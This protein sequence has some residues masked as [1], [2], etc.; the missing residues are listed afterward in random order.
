MKVSDLAAKAFDVKVK[1]RGIEFDYKPLS[2]A[3]SGEIEAAFAGERPSVPWKAPPWAGSEDYAKFQRDPTDATY[4]TKLAKYS[5]RVA[6]A[7]LAVSFGI[8]S[9]D[10]LK[11]EAVPDA[12]RP[13]WLKEMATQFCGVVSE[14]EMEGVLT[15]ISKQVRS[16]GTG[17]ALTG[18]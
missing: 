1:L 18:N 13:Q 5:N 3:L 7:K 17:M 9:P 11:Y 10:G 16:L 6:A 8:E 14:D 12:N 2:A 15:A 4:Q